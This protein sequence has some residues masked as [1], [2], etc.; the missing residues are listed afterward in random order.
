MRN[1]ENLIGKRKI[2]KDIIKLKD[3]NKFY[4]QI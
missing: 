3:N 2:C 1:G 4:D